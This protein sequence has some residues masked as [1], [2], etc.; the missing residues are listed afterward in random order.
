MFLRKNSEINKKILAIL[1]D[2]CKMPVKDIAK[3]LRMPMTTVHSRIKKME[4][5]GII[6]GYVAQVDYRKLGK[7]VQAFVNVSLSYSPVNSTSYPQL[8]QQI[9]SLTGIEQCY[10]ISGK[11]D[12][13]LFVAA[14]DVNELND[15]IAELR[16]IEGV[17][18]TRTSIV[19]TDIFED[20]KDWKQSPSKPISAP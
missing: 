4:R 6:R 20:K 2:N 16:K 7:P 19:M 14:A 17:S 1:R 18:D 11:Y 8:I 9:T 3:I 12:L 15:F 10:I 13:L 5:D